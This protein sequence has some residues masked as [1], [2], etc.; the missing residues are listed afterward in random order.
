MVLDHV[1]GPLGFGPYE[2]YK[3]TFAELEE[4][5][6]GAGPKHK[7]V[8]IKL[9]GLG[10]PL[11]LYEFFKQP[12]PPSFGGAGACS[13]GSRPRSSCRRRP[14]HVRSNFPGRQDHVGFLR[15]VQYLQAAGGG[16]LGCGEDCPFSAPRRVFTS[17]R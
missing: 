10:M 3:E 4:G 6:D 5:H 8:N 9:G 12:L 16:L 2:D 17:W 1:G 14:L 11:G 13:P 7:N 15:A